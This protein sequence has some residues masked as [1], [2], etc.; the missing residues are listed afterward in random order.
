MTTKQ[1]EKAQQLV[2]DGRIEKDDYAAVYEVQGFRG[3]SYFVIVHED[4]TQACTCPGSA[5]AKE[6]DD[7]TVSPPCYHRMAVEAMIQMMEIERTVETDLE[8]GF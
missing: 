8:Y 2:V 1:A 3:K 4:R 5:L 6:R 7:L